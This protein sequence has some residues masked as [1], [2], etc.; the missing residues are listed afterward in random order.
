[1][2]VLKTITIHFNQKKTP[3][4]RVNRIIKKVSKSLIVL[5]IDCVENNMVKELEVYKDVK[6]VE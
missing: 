3:E 6:T 5:D 4:K 2:I 1:M